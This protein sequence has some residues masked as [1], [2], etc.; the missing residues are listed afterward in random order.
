MK[1][2]PALTITPEELDEGLRIARPRR[3]RDRLSDRLDGRPL[4]V[5]TSR[6]VL[7]K[8]SLTP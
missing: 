1:L 2:L 4:N 5:R 7:R 8:G 3:P 6:T